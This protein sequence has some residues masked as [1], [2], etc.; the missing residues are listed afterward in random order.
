MTKT[1]WGKRSLKK[2]PRKEE[3]FKLKLSNKQTHTRFTYLPR[4]RFIK[5]FLV[6]MFL[7]SLLSDNVILGSAGFATVRTQR[8]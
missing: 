2:Q 6:Q 4:Y 5:I 3:N 7:D 8:R 1:V